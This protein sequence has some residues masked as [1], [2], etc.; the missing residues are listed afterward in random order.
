ME[1]PVPEQ[2]VSPQPKVLKQDDTLSVEGLVKFAVVGKAAE[3][4]SP[5]KKGAQQKSSIV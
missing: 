1:K 4:R 5:A 2:A 3:K